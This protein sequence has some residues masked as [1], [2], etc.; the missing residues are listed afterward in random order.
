MFWSFCLIGIGMSVAAVPSD[1]RADVPEPVIGSEPGWVDF[2]YYTWA[3]ADSNFESID[4]QVVFGDARD[5]SG[6]N[7][8]DIAWMTAFTR[9]VQNAHPKVDDPMA[10]LDAFYSRQQADGMIPHNLD[11]ELY[12]VQRPLFALGEW[13]YYRHCADTLRLRR[14]LPVLHRFFQAVREKKGSPEGPYRDTFQGNGMANRPRGPF[15]IDLTAQQALNALLLSRLSLDAG[16]EEMHQTY[17]KE[18]RFLKTAINTIMW[19]QQDRFYADLRF[20]LEPFN[21]WSIASFWPMWAEVPNSARLQALISALNDPMNFNTPH[22]VTTLGRQNDEFYTENGTYWLGAVY[23]TTNTMV[24]KGLAANDKDSLA[25][26]IASNHLLSMFFTWIRG[27]T[28]HD[29]YN[30]STVGLPGGRTRD[31]YVG[32]GGITPIHTLFEHILGIRVDA[33]EHTLH[34]RLHRT[35]THGIRNLGWGNDWAH[36]TDLI[37]TM[38]ADSSRS[39]TVSSNT[40]FKL[41]ISGAVDTTLSVERGEDQRFRVR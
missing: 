7:G 6:L 35:D 36:R 30:Q 21:R 23:G 15:L 22:R 27:G 33:P 2:Y 17:A 29:N 37:A 18:Y 10:A 26:E 40:P 16:F 3:L 1:W 9:Y 4:S 39:I 32:T 34:W 20:N 28:I 25:T 11:A 12:R 24:I 5:E 38:E 13:F 31:L 14:V 8:A 41:L 19:D